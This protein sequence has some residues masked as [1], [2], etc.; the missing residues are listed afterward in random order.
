MTRK[1]PFVAEALWPF[2]YSDT[3]LPIGRGQTISQPYVVALIAEALGLRGS[4]R[5]LEVGS[6]SGYAAAVIS[7][8]GTEVFGIELEQ[9]AP[10]SE[11]WSLSR[12]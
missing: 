1:G 5:V 7:L 8:L 12:D 6:G 2:A 4:E 3:S 10:T 11:A 9:G